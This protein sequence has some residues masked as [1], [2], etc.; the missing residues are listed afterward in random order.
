[1]AQGVVSIKLDE[2]I[3]FLF[4]PPEQDKFN[5]FVEEIIEDTLLLAEV[6]PAHKQR[7]IKEN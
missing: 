7:C 2:D 5:E 4:V 6:S 3:V 1:M